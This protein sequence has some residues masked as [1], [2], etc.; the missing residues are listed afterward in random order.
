M[1]SVA[2]ISNVGAAAS[3]FAKDNYYTRDTD[4]PSAW[5]GK[6]AEALGLLGQVDAPTFEAMLSGKLPN[7]I[8]LGTTRDGEW[9][10]KPGWDL[11]FSAPKSVSLIALVA[12]DAKLLAAH[13][14]AV[15]AAMA[16]VEAPRS[17]WCQPTISPPRCSGTTS[18]GTRSRSCTPM[19]S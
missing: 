10:H 9:Q 15:Q 6:A 13:D 1:L 19:P 17:T 14:S 4:A 5:W 7:G 2:A 16:H 3:Y 8:E 12:G 18:T 11:T